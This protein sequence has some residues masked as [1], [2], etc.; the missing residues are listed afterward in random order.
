M[1]AQV[2]QIWASTDARDVA[3]NSRQERVVTDVRDGYAYLQTRGIGARTGAYGVKLSANGSIPRHRYV[4]AGL[5]PQRVQDAA[6]RADNL[7]A[8]AEEL[9]QQAQ[10]KRAQAWQLRE[11][12]ML[13]A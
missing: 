12:W 4:S 11:A 3:L 2:G 10:A 1:K 6:Q 7:D 5:D 9:Y 13:P 8:E